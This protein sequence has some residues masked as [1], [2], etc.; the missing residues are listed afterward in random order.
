MNYEK[1]KNYKTINLIIYALP[2]NNLRKF[3]KYKLVLGL[4]LFI[5]RN[6]IKMMNATGR[7]SALK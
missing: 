5:M 1:I 4:F 6:E 2:C 7:F 3:S